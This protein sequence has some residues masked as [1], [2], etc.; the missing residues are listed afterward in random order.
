LYKP[1]D[2]V[3]GRRYPL[4]IQT[5]GFD[6]DKFLPN[7]GLPTAFAAQELAA[8]GI[9]VLQIRGEACPPDTPEEARCNAANYEAAANELVKAGIADPDGLGIIGFSRTCY[10]VLEE[11]TA[12]TLHVKAA[13]I[14][15]GVNYGYFQ[16]LLSLDFDQSNL[17]AREADAIIGSPPFGEGLTLWLKRSP[18][19]RMDRVETPLQVVALDN[20]HSLVS[21]WEP[22]AALRYL[23]K[24]VD[25]IIVPDSEHVMT[26]PGERMI[27]QGGTVD[28]F[29]FWLKGEEDPDPDKVQQYVRW[30]ELRQLP[31]TVGSS[32]PSH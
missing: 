14:T 12:G 31:K 8:L 3:P 7:G 13:A 29:R 32:F 20:H 2:Y 22:Y 19:F 28:W 4:V 9:L 18:T 30:R 15:D 23:R 10:H 27:S 16:Y 24:P 26:S 17:F 25:L 21:M 6:D 11:L 5:H 1:P